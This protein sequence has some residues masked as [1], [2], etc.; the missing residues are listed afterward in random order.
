MCRAR[1]QAA[2]T[3]LC[4]SAKHQTKTTSPGHDGRRWH[5]KSTT[6]D[7]CAHA[8]DDGRAASTKWPCRARNRFLGRWGAVLAAAPGALCGLRETTPG[9]QRPAA[10]PGLQ[11]G[12]KCAAVFST[13]LPL[14]TLPASLMM[15]GYTLMPA[16][17]M[18]RHGGGRVRGEAYPC[19]CCAAS[20][21]AYDLADVQRGVVA[22]DDVGHAE[23]RQQLHIP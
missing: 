6:V 12:N 1:Y 22:R 3:P 20:S 23:L 19:S 21:T 17:Q 2:R 14:L 16:C 10:L 13:A 18:W 5:T 4:T 15:K 8:V 11:T 7:A 9:V